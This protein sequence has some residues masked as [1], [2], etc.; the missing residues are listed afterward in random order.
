MIEDVYEPL[1]RYR[2]DFRGRFAALAAERLDA[3]VGKSGV[4]IRANAK[5]SDEA[6][7]LFG[8]ARSHGRWK[9]FHGIVSALFFVA[10]A[11]SAC[12]CCL[13]EFERRDFAALVA[14]GCVALGL[15]VLF[16]VWCRSRAKLQRN[17]EDAARAKRDEAWAQMAPLNGLFGWD[18]ANRL[19][20]KTVPRVAFDPYFTA[21]RLDA[22]K[23]LYG[24]DDSFFAGKSMLFVQSGRING[25]PFVFGQ[26]LE[27]EWGE[28]TYEG[29]K[30][31]SWTEYERDANGRRRAV[32]RTQT[33]HA[34]VTKPIPVYGDHKILLYGNDAAPRLSFSR[35]PSGLSA[36][37]GL[38]ESLKKRRRLADLREFSRN[39]DDDSNFTLMSNEEF[40]TWF[41]AKD[42]DD[43][44]EFRLLFT[45]VA[46]TQMLTLMKDTEIGFGD[47]FSFV[48]S[49]KMNFLSSVHLDA[50]SINT[51]PSRFADWDFRKVGRKFADFSAAYFKDVYFALAP[52][53][54][55][56]L[57]QQTRTHEDIWREFASGESS[58][59]WEH[60]AIANYHGESH[61]AHPECM[62]RSILKT[63]VAAREDGASVVSVTASGY[64]GIDRVEYKSVYGNDGRW[65]DV[66]VRWV[67]YLPVSHTGSI[68]VDEREKPSDGFSSRYAQSSAS[69]FRR[70]IYSFVR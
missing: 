11:L 50:G 20:E 59:S 62:T 14:G 23:R 64:K 34:Y 24:L 21:S 37:G 35:R 63:R 31:I 47:D 67:E 51:D 49:G 41:H 36:K 15:G 16:A 5:T 10:C 7:A 45:P 42:R 29:T 13:G 38:F 66:P 68:C 69:A 9:T 18:E 32:R 60:E 52:L 57:Y 4:D 61:F 70:S 39:L 65:H 22:L 48:K 12:A 33:L 46:Q 1:A 53:L 44:V 6:L 3:L 30:T 8:S 19:I 17:T 43:E 28:K 58:S 27:M 26:Y 56:P 25:N 54:A 40:E 55:I 2:D